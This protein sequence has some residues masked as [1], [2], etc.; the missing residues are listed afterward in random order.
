MSEQTLSPVEKIDAAIEK[1]KTRPS[2]GYL[3]RDGADILSSDDMKWLQGERP[4]GAR[5]RALQVMKILKDREVGETIYWAVNAFIAGDYFEN[6]KDWDQEYRN[7]KYAVEMD[8]L[9][10]TVPASVRKHCIPVIAET[11]RFKAMMKKDADYAANLLMD[12]E[13]LLPERDRSGFLFRASV[14]KDAEVTAE[15]VQT[16]LCIL[17]I[18]PPKDQCPKGRE[19]GTAYFIGLNG[20]NNT[21]DFKD[22]DAVGKRYATIV[23]SL[24]QESLAQITDPASPKRTMLKQAERLFLGKLAA[25][26]G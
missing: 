24:L 14:G 25:N 23:V 13:D 3:A 9:L 5:Y 19:H 6:D 26:Q 4:Q 15:F 10:R 7:H 8:E 12:F 22:G 17:W 21:H 1:L 16:D 20:L 2:F 18:H 11:P